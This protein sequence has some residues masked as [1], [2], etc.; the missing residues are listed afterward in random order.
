MKETMREMFKGYVDYQEQEY[1]FIWENA[2]IVFDT[3][4]LLNFYRYSKETRKTMFEILDNLKNRLWIPYQVAYEFYKNR[5]NVIINA[6]KKYKELST[7][8]ETSFIDIQNKINQIKS[9][10]LK[11][12]KE[13]EELLE[14]ENKKIQDLLEKERKEKEFVFEKDTIEEKIVQLLNT[15]IGKPFE[16]DE[17]EIIKEEGLRRMKEKIPPGYEDTDKEENGDYYIFY[18]MIQE[19]INRNKPIIFVTDDVK[20]DW[21]TKI[22]GKSGGRS[23]L[24]NE[25]YK[26][27]NNLLLIYTSDG[28]V[29]AYNK[30]FNPKK[31]DTK[32][33][34][35]LRNVRKIE[36]IN[37]IT[38]DS[39]YENSFLLDFRI[40]HLVETSSTLDAN[41][42][43]EIIEEM[44]LNNPLNKFQKMKLKTELDKLVEEFPLEDLKEATKDRI[45]VLYQKLI[46]VGFHNQLNKRRYDKLVEDIQAFCMETI[47]NL[48]I[49]RTDERQQR[50]MN[51]IL[52][53]TEIYLELCENR[54]SRPYQLLTKNMKDLQIALAN[55]K[56]DKEFV[57]KKLEEFCK[58]EIVV[59]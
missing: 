28:F 13:I 59:T 33:L 37:Y 16:E 20:E 21:M 38:P 50:I 39:A 22:N 23:E 32:L 27:A 2:F 29:H 31:T 4:I 12:K 49:C 45:N 58:K 8:M 17:Y 36:S 1:K 40:K 10:Q 46:T 34:D 11:C 26:K 57:I 53:E 3:N 47:N 7:L 55:N 52:R 35:E 19:S 41:L 15:N 30:N 5:V 24:L 44:V 6:Q 9:N 14:K 56:H 54:M 48:R 18:S 51:I 25:F 42:K 43:L